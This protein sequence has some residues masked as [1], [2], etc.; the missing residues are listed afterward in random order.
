MIELLHKRLKHKSQSFDTTAK[1]GQ[2]ENSRTKLNSS[3]D[4]DL[5]Y[6]NAFAIKKKNNSDRLKSQ[7]RTS[8]NL[9]FNEIKFSDEIFDL[10]TQ[11]NKQ[12]TEITQLKTQ[13]QYL[14]TELEKKTQENSQ[15]YD[16]GHLNRV[17]N[18]QKRFISDLKEELKKK[19]EKIDEIKKKSKFCQINEMETQIT[20]LTEEC[21]KL[22]NGI[23]LLSENKTRDD[24]LKY[25]E[26]DIQ[27]SILISQLKKEKERFL[28]SIEE[29]NQEILKWRDRVVELE[30]H[31]AKMLQQKKKREKNEVKALKKD[32]KDLKN[33]LANN[34]KNCQS[35]ENK[36][37]EKIAKMQLQSLAEKHSPKN[38]VGEI[39]TS[40][41]KNFKTLNPVPMI[42]HL[43]TEKICKENITFDQFFHNLTLT[44][45]NY[46]NLNDVW[47]ALDLTENQH[48][49][50]DELSSFLNSKS[51]IPIVL[52]KDFCQ[53][54]KFT[55][56]D[57]QKIYQ[58]IVLRLQSSD[59]PRENIGKKL[60]PDKKAMKNMNNCIEILMK[61]PLDLDKNSAILLYNYLFQS[62]TS[63]LTSSQIVASFIIRL[64]DWVVL[65]EEEKKVYTSVLNKIIEDNVGKIL[66]Q[67]K[68]Y[69][70]E[71]TGFISEIEFL[72]CLEGVNARIDKKFEL[73]IK[74]EAY[75][76]AKEIGKVRFLEFLNHFNTISEETDPEKIVNYYLM[77]VALEIM[78]RNT[79]VCKVF[80]EKNGKVAGEGFIDGLA[81]IGMDGINESHLALILEFLQ[82]KDSEDL[83]IDLNLLETKIAG[84]MKSPT[85]IKPGETKFVFDQ[86]LE[87]NSRIKTS[88]E[89]DENSL[90]I[91]NP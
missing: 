3:K 27:K 81:K 38:V 11:L 45:S 68:D 89:L 12:I 35:L 84:I 70:I 32:I 72:K 7:D 86:T 24:L 73:F 66:Q 52:F 16:V 22:L 29:K 44:Y 17:L 37:E 75:K 90:L 76:M 88:Q 8:R 67:C 28:E 4:P 79:Q 39:V 6:K 85:K 47:Q 62:G 18:T 69:D 9:S 33:E 53:K 14:Q 49:F 83:C 60:F 10:K 74:N 58:N 21:K 34:K 31:E 5:I 64:P 78:N 63:S 50:I 80:K 42:I 23:N 71:K 20:Y 87:F 40:Q 48:H 57:V 25:Q 56:Q 43:I 91:S 54:A 41:S 15:T 13:I 46:P 61:F 82:C 51:I 36:Y 2:G 30:T 55:P 65:T 59:F 19:D 1:S 26:D 77:Q